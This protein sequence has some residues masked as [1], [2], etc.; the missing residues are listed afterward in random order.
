MNR[1]T[2]F[3]GRCLPPKVL[4]GISVFA[5]VAV[6]AL[7]MLLLEDVYRD[8]GNVY[9][10]CSRLFAESHFR[11]AMNP[12]LPILPIVSAGTLAWITGLDALDALI[13]S[14]GIFFVAQIPLLYVFLKRFLSPQLAA[15]GV[16]L[17]VFAPKI[18]RF[19]VAGM[20]ESPRNFFLLLTVWGICLLFDRPR[21]SRA[22]LVAVGMVGFTLSRSEGFLVSLGLFPVMVLLLLAAHKGETW[23]KRVSIA[24]GYP[25]LAGCFFVLLLLPRIGQNLQETG[26]P[27]PDARLNRYLHRTVMP[28]RPLRDLSEHSVRYTEVSS[29]VVPEKIPV[30]KRLC[31]VLQQSVRGGYEVYMAFA[32]I[33][34][35]A[36]LFAGWIRSRLPTGWSPTMSLQKSGRD[37]LLILAVYVLHSICY[38]PIKPAYRYYVFLI[39]LLMPLTMTGIALVW[40]ILAKFR[41]Q[42]P[43]G[44]GALLLLIGQLENG[45]LIFLEQNRDYQAGGRW[46]RDYFQKGKS[47]RI[48]NY[49]SYVVYWIDGTIVNFFYEGPSTRPEYASDFDVAIVDPED[50]RILNVFRS[51]KDVEE[52]RHPFEKTVT[53]FRKKQ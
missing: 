15:W 49:N 40:S 26:Y 20:P 19:T 24:V 42:I 52:L 45:C 37:L 21:W 28:D 22:L 35:L 9:A 30:W 29:A 17:T 34:L 48:L 4:L 44:I 13:L 18:I 39:P 8:V 31:M 43:A 7:S 50:E 10:T 36:L 53:V 25:L 5:A 16:L 33:G 2:A 32:G 11:E 14:G 41:C 6:T 1:W 12:A 47:L 3:L 46:I 27:T 51:R 38:F 23:K